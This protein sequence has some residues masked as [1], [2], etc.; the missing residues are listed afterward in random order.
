MDA[1]LELLVTNKSTKENRDPIAIYFCKDRMSFLQ[2]IYSNRAKT[3]SLNEQSYLWE[4]EFPFPNSLL[5]QHT[6]D[7]QRC[8]TFFYI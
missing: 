1:L 2:A 6:Y 3:E 5:W 7:C 4:S 8:F